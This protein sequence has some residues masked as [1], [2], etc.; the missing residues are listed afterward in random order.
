VSSPARI[1]F[2][3]SGWRASA[4]FR[5]AA[6]RP[7]NFEIT[8]VLAHT[9]ASAE[10]VSEDWGLASTTSVSEFRLAGPFDY[11]IVSVPSRE[12]LALALP[13]LQEN[14][15][16]LCETPLGA[17]THELPEFLAR[18]GFS[19]PLQVA[20]QYHRQPMHA[21]RIRVARS[22][23]L[24][25]V[26]SATV[27]VAHGYHGVS[28]VRSIL[29]GDF[30]A[31]T[32]SAIRRIDVAVN[33]LGRS[34][35]SPDLVLRESERLQAR[36]TFPDTNQYADFDFTD[37][38][39]FS[40]IRSRHLSIRGDHGELVDSSVRHIHT[41]GELFDRSLMRVE[42]GAD[43]DLGGLHL[44]AITLG[45]DVLWTNPF[46]PA[47]LSDDELAIASCMQAMTEFSRGGPPFY[48]IA[49][50][51][52]DAYLA[53]LIHESASTGAPLSTQARPWLGQ[54]SLIA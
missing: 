42:T 29:G 32:V 34:G 2:I 37:S 16:V 26:Q 39:Y 5:I 31:I 14:I 38:Q 54:T 25:R 20:E 33:S 22:G 27:A 3:G 17:S 11:V 40:P 52:E 23:V 15:P 35:W 19:A 13:L 21:A 6:A 7:E 45:S 10:R 9:E 53:E 49:D 46:A 36:L 12:A 1:G 51:A 50:A 18:V 24:G 48:G 47:R 44:R 4:Y 41:P 28:L 8:R 30:R 43:G